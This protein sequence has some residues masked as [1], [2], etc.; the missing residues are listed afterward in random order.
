MK[1][2]IKMKPNYTVSEIIC[3]DKSELKN[4]RTVIEVINSEKSNTVYNAHWLIKD[5]K[6]IDTTIGKWN[7]KY[8]KQ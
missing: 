3:Y 6:R 1:T 8:K 2:Q 4:F 7:I 5:F